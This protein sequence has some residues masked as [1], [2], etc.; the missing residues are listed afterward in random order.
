M[1]VLIHAIAGMFVGGLALGIHGP[2]WG[3]LDDKYV[4]WKTGEPH[5]PDTSPSYLGFNSG[6]AGA[7][8]GLIVGAILGFIA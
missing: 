7:I 4:K 3:V 6:L 2:L 5:S 8:A 1:T